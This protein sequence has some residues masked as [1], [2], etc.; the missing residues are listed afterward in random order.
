LGAENITQIEIPLLPEEMNLADGHA[1]RTWT[2]TE[3]EAALRVFGQVEELTRLDLPRLEA[4]Y[5]AALFSIGPKKRA[6][7]SVICS[8]ASQALEIIANVLRLQGRRRVCLVEPCFDNLADIFRR[9]D[10]SLVPFGDDA[11]TS[12]AWAT[13][14]PSEFDAVCAVSPNNP[15]GAVL[16]DGAVR[17]LALNCERAGAALI[18]DSCFRVFDGGDS[19]DL[20]DALERTL[21]DWAIIEDTGKTWPTFELK[22][23][24]LTVSERLYP[25][26]YRV[27]TD[28]MLHASP[29]T[30]A[31]LTDMIRA[32][33]AENHAGVRSIIAANSAA[34]EAALGERFPVVSAPF[35]SVAWIRT[36]PL[37]GEQFAS[38][39]RDVGV[40]VLAG[41]RFFW[42][43]RGDVP[44]VRV[45][46]NR[47]RELIRRVAERVGQVVAGLP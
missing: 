21:C 29:L 19:V 1:F 10:A 35:M 32:S 11:F 26:M 28:M 20:Y 33:A 3:R 6:G 44:F 23:S 34:L 5:L 43:G 2:D 9:H 15:S 12:S 36:T 8:S 4:D 37:S 18:V 46:L 7:T 31:L 45:A 17:E 42:S 16:T 47:D 22:G 25:P 24:V 14:L 38:A 41:R 40:H 30:L 27:Y 13:A 39:L